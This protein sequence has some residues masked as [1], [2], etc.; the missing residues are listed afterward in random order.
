M[1]N[2]ARYRIDQYRLTIHIHVLIAI[3]R[4]RTKRD[5]LRQAGTYHDFALQVNW[6]DRIRLDVVPDCGRR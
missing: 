4:D 5:V 3:V 2:A 1:H 6:I